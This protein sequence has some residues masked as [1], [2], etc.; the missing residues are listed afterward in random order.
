MNQMRHG[1]KK[2]GPECG[3]LN[4]TCLT[5]ILSSS[6]HRYS[7][8]CECMYVCVC[9]YVFLEKEGKTRCYFLKSL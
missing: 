3:V 1:V 6:L 7:L 4:E 9:V 8:R 5:L 2:S